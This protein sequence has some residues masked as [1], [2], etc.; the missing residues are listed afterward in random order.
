MTDETLEKAKELKDK[1]EYW[2]E[3]KRALCY[4]RSQE[5][6]NITLHYKWDMMN[7]KFTTA[8]EKSNDMGINEEIS[9]IILD[10][11]KSRLAEAE[12]EFK[13]L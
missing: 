9:S 5:E 11:V 8:N 7:C 1:I 12:E 6:F 4:A 2:E 3:F 13:N 10:Y